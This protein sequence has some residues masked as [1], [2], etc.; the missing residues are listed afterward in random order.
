V[1][2]QPLD[3]PLQRVIGDDKRRSE[4]ED[5]MAESAP[6]IEDSSMGCT[7]ERTLSVGAQ[8]VVHN[9]FLGLGACPSHIS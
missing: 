7:G 6:G 4:V 1:G 2:G 5:L 8:S 9:A 3:S